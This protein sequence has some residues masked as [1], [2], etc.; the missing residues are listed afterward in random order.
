MFCIGKILPTQTSNLANYLGIYRRELPTLNGFFI[1]FARAKVD[2]KK[3]VTFET[4][5]PT[6]PLSL[7]NAPGPEYQCEFNAIP[8]T[9]PKIFQFP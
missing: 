1:Y 4:T 3:P 6:F 9:F 7:I 5:L 2:N 8:N